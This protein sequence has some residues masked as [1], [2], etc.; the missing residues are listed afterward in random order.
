MT[1]CTAARTVALAATA[2]LLG[3]PAPATAAPFDLIGI[4]A[5]IATGTRIFYG[6][7]VFTDG[8]L[9]GLPFGEFLAR[10]PYSGQVVE[11]GSGDTSEA[12][13]TYVPG[14]AGPGFASAEASSR[15]LE[16]GVEKLNGI[17]SGAIALS[18]MNLTI[19][20]HHDDRSL[21]LLEFAYEIP[22]GHIA[23]TDF[24][25]TFHGIVGRVQA[26]IDYVLL[27][28]DGEFGGTYEETTGALLDY[29]VSVGHEG[30]VENSPSATIASTANGNRMNVKIAS[31]D[32]K[33]RLPSIPPHG[34]LRVYYDMH[35]W[36]S[37]AHAEVLGEAFLGDPTNLTT[38]GGVGLALLDEEEDTGPSVPEPTT[39]L[40]IVAGILAAA[41]R[42]RAASRES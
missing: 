3:A 10:R 13:V 41:A 40:L 39:T 34:Q 27:S 38:D 4:T 2:V 12:Y 29:V 16:V 37:S 7:N 21:N 15:T 36:V 22:A 6:A 18:R 33:V 8:Q 9:I 30:V 1:A 24:S 11:W 26:S 17:P 20:N 35:A 14:D 32:G 19:T 5:E 28:P 25:E 42:S 31:H 23:F